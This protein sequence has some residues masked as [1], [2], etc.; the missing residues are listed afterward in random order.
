MV[1][2]AELVSLQF[3]EAVHHCISFQ[4]VELFGCLSTK[5]NGDDFREPA[6]KQAARQKFR[7]SN[8]NLDPQRPLA[9]TPK[10]GI[11]L[12]LSR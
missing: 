5:N 10:H 2:A 11:P 1:M 6:K 3:N 7:I 8:L 9:K 12:Y 4:C